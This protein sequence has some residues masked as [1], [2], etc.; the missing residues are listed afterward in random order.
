[1]ESKF[2]KEN[3]EALMNQVEDQSAA[4]F[5]SG[6]AIRKSSDEDY[7]FF[8]NRNFVYLTGVEQKETILVMEKD[9]GSVREKLYI[10]PPDAMEE[11]WTGRR[12][13]PEEAESVSEVHSFSSV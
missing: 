13:K 7:G 2:Y 8:A 5:F 4:I 12:I 6:R 9:G 3:R 11:R 1:M 10:L